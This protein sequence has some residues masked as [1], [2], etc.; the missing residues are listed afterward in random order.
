MINHK[1]AWTLSLVT[2]A[3]GVFADLSL[4]LQRPLPTVQVDTSYRAPDRAVT[5]NGQIQIE[6]VSVRKVAT[7][8]REATFK[9]TNR[10]YD[11][12]RFQG[13]GRDE[14]VEAWVRENGR[15]RD[16]WNIE[17][18]GVADISE[19]AIEPKGFS[20]FTIPIPARGD[21]FDV[22]FDFKLGQSEQ[23]IT[24]WYL[25]PEFPSYRRNT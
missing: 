5:L 12:I 1:I 4:N 10:R 15:I 20:Y 23:R 13:M 9:V 8:K 21:F 11:S 2:F 25:F 18:W 22:G 14:T 19:Y 16:A 7:G 24:V 6:L 3:L 17:C